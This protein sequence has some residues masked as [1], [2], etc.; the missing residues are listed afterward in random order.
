MPVFMKAF[1]QTISTLEFVNECSREELREL[2]LLVQDKLNT[3]NST[4][5]PERRQ[6]GFKEVDPPTKD[7]GLGHNGLYARCAECDKIIRS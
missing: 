1:T 7:S 4:D 2:E 3:L 6:H 5:V